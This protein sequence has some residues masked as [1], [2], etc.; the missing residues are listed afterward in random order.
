M[1]R[2]WCLLLPKG[3]LNEGSAKLLEAVH[4]VTA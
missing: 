4:E 2:N 1:Q 3:G